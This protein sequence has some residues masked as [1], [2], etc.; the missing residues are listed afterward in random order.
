[1]T[2]IATTPVVTPVVTAT[3]TFTVTATAVVP[4]AVTGQSV[5]SYTLVNAQTDQDIRDLADGETIDLATLGTTQINVRINTNPAKVGSLVVALNT[6]QKYRVDENPPYTMANTSGTDYLAWAYKNGQNII[7]A[8]PF[9]AANGTG[10]AGTPLTITIYVVNSAV[11]PAP[12]SP[13]SL[14]VNGDFSMLN[15]AQPQFPAAWTASKLVDSTVRCI[16]VDTLENPNAADECG[17]RF[18]GGDDAQGTLKQVTTPNDLK[19]GDVVSLH[20]LASAKKAVSGGKL[21]VKLKYADGQK[22]ALRIVLPE[23]TYDL[24]DFS[25]MLMLKG[26]VVRL[27]VI[28]RYSGDRGQVVMDGI[29]LESGRMIEEEGD[30]GAIPLPLDAPVTEGGEARFSDSALIDLPAIP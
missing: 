1:V 5:V 24:T 11:S 6:N 16:A 4:T 28:A 27:K 21:I 2:P 10:T 15:P 29:M 14:I 25:D 17:F 13:P 3:A 7:K 12:A 18:K 8:T 9:S 20:M 22:D 26:D 30:G 19:A 23:G